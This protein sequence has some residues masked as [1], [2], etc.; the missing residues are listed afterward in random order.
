MRMNEPVVAVVLVEVE[1][2]RLGERQVAEADVVERQRAGGKLLEGV[3]VD[4]VLQL[5]DRCAD[6][7]GA[8]LQQIRAAGQ[9]RL[10]RHPDD[11]SGDL[12]GNLGATVGRRQYV[13]AADVDLD[14]RRQRHRIAGSGLVAVAVHGDDA[15]H[16]RRL[17]GAGDD[18]RIARAHGAGGDS[19]GIAAEAGIRPVDPLDRKA[20]SAFGRTIG[21][22][23]FLQVFEQRRSAIPGRAGAALGDVISVAGGDGNRDQALEAEGGAELRELVADI[24]E[25]LFGEADQV[26]LVHRQH[27]V[28]N[29]EQR[30]DVGMAAGLGDDAVLGVDQK[31][32]EIGRRGAGRHVAGVLDVAGRVGDDEA[33]AVGGEI[34]I[35]DV[36]G[37]ALLA[38]GG[39]AIDEKG[40][41]DVFAG[42]AVALR[43]GLQGGELVLEQALGIEQQP[44]DQRRLAVIDA[45]A[46][47]EAQQAL[48]LV[49]GEEAG[50]RLALGRA[51]GHQK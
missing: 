7:A 5:A 14:V 15:L 27:D 38:L 18:D 49:V 28:A 10:L 29:A 50:E 47:Q 45:A 12:V 34:A 33:A 6:R 8:G 16:R 2:D 46:G 26:D 1:G 31:H 35:G 19:A 23:D 22:V 3:D 11:V 4:A 17:A 39:K 20:E 24:D 44:A 30:D 42:G 9:Q 13:A 51:V 48:V 25:R 41:I 40:E 36:D 37:D 32:G 43:V 21:D